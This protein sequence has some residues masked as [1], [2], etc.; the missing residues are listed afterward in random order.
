MASQG[1]TQPPAGRFP[2]GGWGYRVELA[3]LMLNPAGTHA[4]VGF[5]THLDGV[6]HSERLLLV[7]GQQVEAGSACARAQR[8]Q[9]GSWSPTQTLGG[10]WNCQHSWPGQGV[11]P[12]GGGHRFSATDAELPP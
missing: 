8:G 12:A 11:E 1:T 9:L 4:R 2:C 10:R 5:P 7:G 3:K 6:A